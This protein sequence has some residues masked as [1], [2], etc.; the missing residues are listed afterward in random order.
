MIFEHSDHPFE[1]SF[2]AHQVAVPANAFP[3]ELEAGQRGD[4]HELRSRHAADDPFDPFHF[5]PTSPAT[6]KTA[7]ASSGE[8]IV[9]TGVRSTTNSDD[10]GGYDGT[11]SSGDSGG[12]GSSGSSTGGGTSTAAQAGLVHYTP[13]HHTYI[14]DVNL[15]SAQT[16]VLD[17]IVDY[18]LDHNFT[19]S[20]VAVVA[21]D[22]YYES[23]FSQSAVNGT[24]VGTFQY[25]PS[26]WAANGYS[27][28]ISSLSDQISAMF[29]DISRYEDRYTA[30]LTDTSTGLAA[31]GLTFGQYFEIKHELGNSSVD[32]NGVNP[33][34][35]DTYVSDWTNKYNELHIH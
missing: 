29:S 19:A 12:I 11:W 20:E 23:S 22:A 16:Q 15:T 17:Q 33:V 25:D 6:S 30:A 14:I 1:V 32:W 26:T 21:A 4:N 35:G 8:E 27:G 3:H 5:A 31:A 2:T 34:T 24:H 7:W 13:E 9:V 18:G 28:S 10:G